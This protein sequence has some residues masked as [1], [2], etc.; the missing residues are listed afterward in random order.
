MNKILANAKKKAQE[1]YNDYKLEIIAGAVFVGGMII[2]GKSFD[3][4][5]SCRVDFEKACDADTGSN[6]VDIL[7]AYDA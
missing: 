7:N 4:G 6:I 2:Y 3:Y 1:F 5:Y